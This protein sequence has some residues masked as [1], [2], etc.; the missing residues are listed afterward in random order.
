MAVAPNHPVFSIFAYVNFGC[1]ITWGLGP[2]V[3]SA[4]RPVNPRRK[5]KEP[6]TGLRVHEQNAEHQGQL[7]QEFPQQVGDDGPKVFGDL[8]LMELNQG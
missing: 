7:L 6:G 4:G 8:F 5:V 3:D 1:S 2:Q